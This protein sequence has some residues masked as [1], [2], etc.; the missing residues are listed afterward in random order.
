MLG[1]NFLATWIIFDFSSVFILTPKYTESKHSPPIS[2]KALTS[3]QSIGPL[4]SFCHGSS[5]I[6]VD[7]GFN[8]NKRTSCS[9]SQALA[10]VDI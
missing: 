2:R 5:F 7:H 9:C 3:F 4:L 8:I 10:F 6:Y 1:F